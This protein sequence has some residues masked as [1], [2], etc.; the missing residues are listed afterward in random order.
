MHSFMS[1]VS[2]LFGY[3]F[4]SLFI[5]YTSRNNPKE[6]EDLQNSVRMSYNFLSPRGKVNQE[7]YTNGKGT[8][9]SSTP[10]NETELFSLTSLRRGSDPEREKN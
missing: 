1:M 9:P 6:T 7:K 5:K 8:V 4:Q 10:L 2:W 3:T